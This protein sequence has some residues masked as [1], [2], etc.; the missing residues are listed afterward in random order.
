M[1][2]PRMKAS[3]VQKYYPFNGGLDL[4]TPALS[5][6]PGFAL[7]LV[8][9]EP[10]YNGGY[11]RVDGYEKF[12]GRAKPSVAPQYGAVIS[13]LT[14]LTV[15]TSTSAAGTG[16]TSGATGV[17]VQS[18]VDSNGTSWV[19]LTAVT[20]TWTQGE[21]ILQGTNTSTGVLQSPVSLNYAPLGTGTDG[22]PYSSEFLASAQAYYRNLIGKVPGFGNVLG[23]WQN[24]TSI[25]AFRG[26][27]TATNTSSVGK[28]YKA[29]GTG[30]TA[31]GTYC[32]TLYYTGLGLNSAQGT[33]S[34][35]TQGLMTITAMASGTFTVGMTVSDPTGYIPPGALVQRIVTGTGGVGTIQISQNPTMAV[36]S[37]QIY[38]LN[39]SYNLPTVGQVVKGATSGAFGTMY[40]AVPQDT[41][42]GYLA[43]TSVG[44]TASFA[45]GENLQLAG[46][47]FAQA[48]GTATTFAFP[49]TGFYRFINFNFF[50]NSSAYNI[51][52]V[53]GQ[54]PAFQIDQSGVI[55][56]ILMPQST[57]P[58]QPGTNNPFLINSYANALWLG[59]PGGDA[60]Q[61]VPGVPYQFDGFLGAAEFGIGAELTGMHSVAGPALI[62]NTQRNTQAISGNS[63]ANY[64]QQTIAEKA[65]S[66]LYASVLLDTVYA[67]NNLGITSLSRTQSYGNFVGSTISQLVQ[68]MV[69][70]LRPFFSDATIVRA[71]NEARFYFTDG[72]VLIIY[73]PGLGQQNKAWSAIES[74][75]T[76]QFGYAN[77]PAP[78]YNICN[79]EDAS[80]NE[81]A[82]FGSS[83]GDGYVYQDRSGT[84]W[85][86]AAVTSYVRLAFNNIGSPA[87]RKFFRRADI[88]LNALSPLALKFTADLSYSNQESSSAV[89]ALTAANISPVN[90][91]GG[92]GYWN[93]INWNSFDWDAQTISSARASLSGTGENISFLI[94]HQAIVDVPFILQGLVLH[95]DVRRPQR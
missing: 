15:G 70:T 4:V 39:P 23:V 72:S 57:Q 6:D 73:V 94:F 10:W 77:Y 7:A 24:G 2:A 44:G 91:Y 11:R 8:N 21:K 1:P 62:L 64:T 55:M 14:G 84:S 56:P 25:Y 93:S 47:T 92:G 33:G 16:A 26:T 40:Q 95:Y 13:S 67:L 81:V 78:V 61:S 68:P 3:T 45:N 59:F 27:S 46:V 74:G 86:G 66:I 82:Y 49:S 37:E 19:G 71:T 79:S 20:G 30:W 5:V 29:T 28:M 54:G 34:I 18:A 52:G 32:T 31:A 17:F 35:S 87:V 43:M 58:N 90:I 85:D 60:Q 50:G 76:A 48:S 36:P 88:E 69:A 12:D 51:Y 65:G 9:Y 80:G 89:T 53:N 41:S 83:N 42:S 38:G 75:V 22:Y 63:T